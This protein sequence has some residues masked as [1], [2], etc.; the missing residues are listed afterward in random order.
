MEVGTLKELNVKPGD[1]VEWQGVAEKVLFIEAITEGN[2]AGETRVTLEEYGTGIFDQEEFRI[3]SR[4]TETPKLWRDMT[5]AEKGALLL[6]HH[7]GKVIEEMVTEKTFPVDVSGVWLVW[8]G[9][10]RP[11]DNIAYR[12]RPE[13]KRET[14]TLIGDDIRFSWAFNGHRITFD[15]IDGKPNL[16]SIK[17]EELE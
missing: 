5:D 2:F 17:M 1:V 10:F 6:A 15:L 16:A 11:K 13:P 4:A 9:E 3:I 12:I 8:T 7:E 14:V